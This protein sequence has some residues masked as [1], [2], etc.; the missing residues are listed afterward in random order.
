MKKWVIAIL[1]V[2]LGLSAL[3]SNAGLVTFHQGGVVKA[4]DMNKNFNY[5]LH[6]VQSGAT[7]NTV[8][9]SNNDLKSAISQAQNIAKTACSG[10]QQCKI[11][12]ILKPNTVYSV[13]TLSLPA[14]VSLVGSA[15][16]TSVINVTQSSSLSVNDSRSL[17]DVIINVPVSVS[18]SSLIKFDRCYQVLQAA[19]GSDSYQ[20]CG[21]T[22]K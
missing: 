10:V 20:D 12:V 16:L 8:A 22:A 9:V 11:D 13:N 2:S 7:S 3:V 1:S 19:N 15:D 4:S 6:Q 5:V 14:D 18:T 21:A 17:R